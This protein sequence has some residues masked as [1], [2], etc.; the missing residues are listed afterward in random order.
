[1]TEVQIAKLKKAIKKIIGDRYDENEVSVREDY[2]RMRS[3]YG[4]GDFRFIGENEVENSKAG[5]I[6]RED[7]VCYV[8]TFD[9]AGETAKLL[10]EEM[11]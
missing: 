1:M 4:P 5:F 6:G 2:I 10:T 9:V 11:I 7:K 3:A 8:K